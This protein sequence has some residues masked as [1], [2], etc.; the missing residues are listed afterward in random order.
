MKRVLTYIFFALF[1]AAFCSGMFLLEYYQRQERTSMVCT[2]MEITFLDSLE[3]VSKEDVKNYLNEEYG[4]FIGQMLD[5]VGLGKIESVLESKTAISDCEAWVTDD[6]ILHVDILQRA[7]VVHFQNG[8]QG[9][10]VDDRGYIFPLHPDYTAD[11]PT[12]AG[13][14]PITIPEGYRGEAPAESSRE[15]IAKVSRLTAYMQ[16]TGEWPTNFNRIEVTENGDIVLL[17]ASGEEHFIFGQPELME[18]KFSRIHKYYSV[19]KTVKGDVYETIN[20]KYKGQI[21]CRA[22]GMLQPLTSAQEN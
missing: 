7:P 8:E 11:V 18:D 13:S 22:K 1:V 3:F 2:D 6:G 4:A 15:W 21:V 5:S 17:P 14:I 12:V 9:Y 10:Y 20:V 16:E 19:I